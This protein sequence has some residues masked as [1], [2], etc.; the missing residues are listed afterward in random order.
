[1]FKLLTNWGGV[2][3]SKGTQVICFPTV[4][5]VVM[6]LSIGEFVEFETAIKVIL[7]EK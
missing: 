6:I 5:A 1:M 4:R 2:S 7:F 3:T